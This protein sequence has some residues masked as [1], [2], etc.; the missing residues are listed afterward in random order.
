[1]NLIKDFAHRGTNSVLLEDNIMIAGTPAAAGSKILEGFN[2]LITATVVTRL[3]KAGFK[4]AGTASADQF[5]LPCLFEDSPPSDAVNAVASGA[6]EFALA[7]DVFGRVRAAAVA[8]GCC[9]IRPTYGTVSRFGLIPTATSMDSVGIICRDLSRGYKLLNA[10]AGKDEKDGAMYD[11]ESYNYASPSMNSP[12]ATLSQFPVNIEGAI[13]IDLPYADL[14]GEVMYTLATAEL[15][16]NINRYDGIAF[17]HR[18][19]DA[20][21]LD[22]LYTKTRA[23]LSTDIKFAAIMGASFVSGD[24]YTKLYEQ[25]MK[26]RGMICDSITFDGYDLIA[27]PCPDKLSYENL[28]LFALPALTGLPCVAMEYQGQQVQVI[29]KNLACSGVFVESDF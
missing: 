22:E 15:S 28:G 1:M 2:S 12:I 6:V 8:A 3:E 21:K 14:Y 13:K 11:M 7:N 23:T 17:G 25:A 26:L 4:V 18:A 20:R 19:T 16:H 29:S 10:I 5:G 24:N 9:Y 27:L